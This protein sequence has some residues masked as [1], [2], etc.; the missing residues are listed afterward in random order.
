GGGGGCFPQ[1]TSISTPHG[2]RNI[3]TLQKGDLVIAVRESDRTQQ[4]RAVQRVVAH[5]GRRIWR[6]TFSDESSVRTTATHSLF[7]N[8]RWTTARKVQPGDT[9]VALGTNGRPEEKI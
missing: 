2:V 1:G 7:V 6:L 3:A 8:G 9:V 5:A 4:V